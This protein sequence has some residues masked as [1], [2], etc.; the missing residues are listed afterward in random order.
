MKL[1]RWSMAALMAATISACVSQDCTNVYNGHFA[2]R[3]QHKAIAQG[4]GVCHSVWG[5]DSEEVAK[6]DAMQRCTRAGS[7][8]CRIVAVNGQYSGMTIRESEEITDVLNTV[9][10]MA[11]AAATGFVAAR[12]GQTPYIPGTTPS[13]SSPSP[14]LGTAQQA[15]CSAEDRALQMEMQSLQA[16]MRR[17]GEGIC[18]I[19]RKSA[20]LFDRL[21]ALH[22]RCASFMANAHAQAAAYDR[23]AAAARQTA[24]SSCSPS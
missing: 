17:G 23:Q 2:Q 3:P 1:F 6:R 7:G 14:N 16:S 10:T 24:A 11:G 5:R 12:Y 15:S 9:I 18:S 8:S 20:Q 4:Q 19:S 13:P 21:A 22:R